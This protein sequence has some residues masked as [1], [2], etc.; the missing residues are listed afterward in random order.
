MPFA[1]RAAL[2][3]D[4]LRR[5]RAGDDRAPQYAPASAPSPSAPL[6]LRG[7]R[8]GA[9]DRSSHRVI[10]TMRSKL[11]RVCARRSRRVGAIGPPR[12]A[13][14]AAAMR[15]SRIRARSALRPD[16]ARARSARSAAKTP[17]RRARSAS[18][19]SSDR[20]R[21][22]V[23]PERRGGPAIVDHDQRAPALRAC[24]PR[25]A[26]SLGARTP[27]SAAPP[28]ACGTARATTARV[29]GSALRCASPCSKP[30]RRKLLRA[31]AAAALRASATR[32]PAAR[33]SAANAPRRAEQESAQ[34][35][36]EAL[37]D[38]RDQQR[39][40]RR[41]AMI[42]AVEDARKAELGADACGWRDGAFRAARRKFHA[43]PPR[44]RAALRRV[45][46]ARGN[47][48]RPRNGKSSSAGSAIITS[49]PDAPAS[50]AALRR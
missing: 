20:R 18:A 40:R 19:D 42:G 48:V 26:P 7:Q 39:Q 15:D 35:S 45:R 44:G 21:A 11:P 32:A 49:A 50:A 12:L 27:G 22:R 24:P 25:L 4:A 33:C 46:P 34:S 13:A 37:R 9:G 2:A 8:F 31:A 43:P 47:S 1:A 23:A 10:Q 17:A 36:R 29:R 41:R 30:R 38:E 16:R 6:Q 28:Q 14:Q 5:H 3:L